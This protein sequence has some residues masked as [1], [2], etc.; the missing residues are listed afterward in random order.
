MSHPNTGIAY[1]GVTKAK[2]KDMDGEIATVPR[3]D[4]NGVK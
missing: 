4:E 3:E 1:L 2:Q